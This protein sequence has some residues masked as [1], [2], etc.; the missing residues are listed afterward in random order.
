MAKNDVIEA[1]G[2]V[3]KKLPN[4]LFEVDLG[5]GHCITA[6]LTNKLRRFSTQIM[7]GDKV[8]VQMSFYDLTQGQ[9]TC[10]SK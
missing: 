5:E 3:T 9:I 6:T 4:Q 1:E 7:P 10:R 8:T 2:I